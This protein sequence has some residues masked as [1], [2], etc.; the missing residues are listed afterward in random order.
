M[1]DRSSAVGRRS[2]RRPEG[3][4]RAG[5]A[6]PGARLAS[7]RSSAA[8]PATSGPAKS[9]RARRLDSPMSRPG[10][11]GRARGPARW[12]LFARRP[13]CRPP[14]VAPEASIAQGIAH[15]GRIRVSRRTRTV[16]DARRR[17]CP[18]DPKA[19]PAGPLAHPLDAVA[20]RRGQSAF[21]SAAEFRA[22]SSPG[23]ASPRGPVAAR[24]R[25]RHEV[26]PWPSAYR[27]PASRP[28]TRSGALGTASRQT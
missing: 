8:K 16:D 11:L 2:P 10:R 19:S 12:G 5:A 25:S 22:A 23:R 27:K 13:P 18:A 28:P 26:A 20:R 15:P 21:R 4:R 17:S 24:T 3:D 9:V 7:R 6:W 14:G 1:I